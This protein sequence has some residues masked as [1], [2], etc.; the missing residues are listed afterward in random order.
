MA[1]FSSLSR[2]IFCKLLRL[3]VS[4]AD[5]SVSL[6]GLEFLLWFASL[7]DT[8]LLWPTF[9]LPFMEFSQCC[10]LLPWL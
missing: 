2:I 9:H 1:F 3:A 10:G 5:M 7:S 8:Y 4:V 6:E